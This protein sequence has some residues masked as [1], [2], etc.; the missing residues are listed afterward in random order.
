MGCPVS[1]S[2]IFIIIFPCSLVRL[3]KGSSNSLV[4][5]SS[6]SAI[7]FFSLLFAHVLRNIFQ[8]PE[9]PY[10]FFCIRIYLGSIISERKYL[11]YS[12][13]LA[14]VLKA[15]ILTLSRSTRMSVSPSAVMIAG[16]IFPSTMMR[17]SMLPSGLGTSVCAKL[18]E[19]I[20]EVKT[21]MLRNLYIKC[22]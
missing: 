13:S 22:V 21:I 7:F 17:V 14:K 1:F 9:Y 16:N 8:F 2:I 5:C 19:N 4:S 18:C 11:R 15:V 3:V 20:I 10:G 12:S 6:S